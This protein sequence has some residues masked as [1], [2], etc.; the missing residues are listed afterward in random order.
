MSENKQRYMLM[1]F[2]VLQHQLQAFDHDSTD[3]GGY[4]Y[5]WAHDLC[6]VLHEGVTWHEP[7]QNEFEVSGEDVLTVLNFLGEQW[8][9]KKAVTFYE[10]E[11]HFGVHGSARADGPYT[12]WKLC[13]IVRYL[14]LDGLRFD[15]QFWEALLENGSAPSEALSLDR[16]LRRDEITPL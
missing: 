7:F 8:D 5:A 9:A 10:L 6:P 11:S 16:P 2:S 3:V 12:R 14:A 15:R 13:R 4:A 1:K